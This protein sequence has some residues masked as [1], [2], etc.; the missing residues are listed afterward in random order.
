MEKK[1]ERYFE[2]KKRLM[3]SGREKRDRAK[4]K[5]VKSK[6]KRDKAKG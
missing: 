3:T 1:T 5:R 6:G 4:G 2:R